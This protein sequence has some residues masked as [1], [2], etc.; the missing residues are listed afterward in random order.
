MKANVIHKLL[1]FA[2]VAALAGPIVACAG[3]G[4]TLSAESRAAYSAVYGGPDV[5]KAAPIQ[6]STYRVTR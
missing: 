2:A 5:N 1:R 6:G 4:P 3:W